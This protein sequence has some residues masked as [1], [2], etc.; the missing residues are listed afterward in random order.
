MKA[1]KNESVK[2]GLRV[3]PLNKRETEMASPLCVSTQENVLSIK[4][5]N[6]IKD[7]VFDYVFGIDTKQHQVYESCGYSIV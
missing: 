2:V 4:K 6:D 5:A 1:N 3:R 7:F